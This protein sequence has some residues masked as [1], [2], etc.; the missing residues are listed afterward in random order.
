[1]DPPEASERHT[2]RHKTLVLVFLSFTYL[3]IRWD[4][5]RFVSACQ[6]SRFREALF[7]TGPG[8]TVTESPP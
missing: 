5:I 8:V 7:D 4:E 6:S 1:M 3:M 2:P